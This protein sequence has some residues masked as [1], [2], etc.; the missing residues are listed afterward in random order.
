M[1]KLTLMTVIAIC[2]T[3]TSC[4]SKDEDYTFTGFYSYEQLED[5]Y[6]NPRELGNLKNPI[7]K[8]N[9]L[10]MHTVSEITLYDVGDEQLLDECYSLINYYEELLSSNSEKSETS[11]IYKINNANGEPVQVSDDTLECLEYGY[12]YSKNSMGTFD[13]TIGQLTQ[14][15]NFPEATVAPN[16]EDIKKAVETVDFNNVVIDGNTVYL[17][18]PNAKIDLGGISKGFICD[19]VANYLRSQG[20]NSAI[21]NLGGNVYVLGYKDPKTQQSFKIGIRQ[22]GEAINEEMGYV[23]VH[24]MSIVASGDY[25]IY[26]VDEETGITY[27]HI[28]NKETGYPVETDLT[29]VTIFSEKS[30][31]GDGLSTTVYSLGAKDGMAYVETLD[32]VECI[33]ITKNGDVL[34]SSG[35]TNDDSGKVKFTQ[36]K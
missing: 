33:M 29:Q 17:K 1:K 36:T 21:L 19:K 6:N 30:A 12:E 8:S 28:L 14:L 16:D 2:I 25:E 27:S 22:P 23:E 18:D 10:L 31:D 7:S 3:I 26:F 34:L 24:D 20:V 4:Y 15:W 9:I 5:N 13:I 11:E 35:V 32:D